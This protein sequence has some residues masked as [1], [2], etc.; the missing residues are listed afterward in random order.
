MRAAAGRRRRQRQLGQQAQQRDRRLNPLDQ[1]LT[2]NLRRCSAAATL[3]FARPLLSARELQ[4][5]GSA[6]DLSNLITGVV[7]KVVNETHGTGFQFQ[8]Q[9]GARRGR[10]AGSPP[11][12]AAPSG[13]GDPRASSA[14]MHISLLIYH[15]FASSLQLGMLQSERKRSH[16]SQAPLSSTGLRAANPRRQCWLVAGGMVRFCGPA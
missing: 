16:V 4:V 14:H 5:T 8:C 2:H 11:P 7:R 6:L 13:L 15:E 9:G 10:C 3:A 1:H 12:C